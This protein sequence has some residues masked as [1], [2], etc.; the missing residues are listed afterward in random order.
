MMGYLLLIFII[1]FIKLEIVPLLLFVLAVDAERKKVEYSKYE[2]F[3]YLVFPLIPS[4]VSGFDKYLLFLSYFM[5]II[6]SIKLAA[7]VEPNKK[8]KE[9]EM[10]LGKKRTK[11]VMCAIYFVNI[12]GK[13]A[14]KI[15]MTYKMRGSKDIIK[16]IISLS[17][18]LNE[19][20]KRM[21]ITKAL[22]E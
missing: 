12:L 13:K 14:K 7:K 2:I 21:A 18:F 5:S 4:F 6:L 17:Y 20:A 10:F 1:P 16:M 9:L 22:R 11:E 19:K 3:M 8:R 15:Y